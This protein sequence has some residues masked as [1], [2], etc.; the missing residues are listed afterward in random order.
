[1]AT[2]KLKADYNE[3]IKWGVEHQTYPMSDPNSGPVEFHR[4]QIEYW[5]WTHRGIFEDMPHGSVVDI[6]A[7][8]RHD[9][10]PGLVTMNNH[11]YTTSSGYSIVNPDVIG[12]VQALEFETNSLH[13]ILCMETL[14]HVPEPGLA[15]EEMQRC[16]RPGG[17]L[18]ASTP[19][20]WPEHSGADFL[21]YYRFTENGLRYLLEKAGFRRDATKILATSSKSDSLLPLTVFAQ[22]EVMEW[23]AIDDVSRYTP[24]YLIRA[25]K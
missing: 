20:F 2:A 7:E 14:E 22:K 12:D 4:L 11:A 15:I 6:G 8:W 3:L 24:G 19:F 10:I 23:G 5:L 18:F 1:M 13:A 17:V 16:L 21:D 25:V 9:F